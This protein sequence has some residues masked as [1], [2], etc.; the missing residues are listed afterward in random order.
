MKKSL[1]RFLLLVVLNFIVLY[2]STEIDV[3][4]LL[5]DI[6]FVFGQFITDQNFIFILISISISLLTILLLYFFRPFSEIY[7]THYLKSSYYLMLNLVSISTVYLVF[8]IYGYS[9]LYILIY[10][11]LGVLFLQTLDKLF[12]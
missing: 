8:R 2:R 12:K 10:L 6:N 11:V 1:L 5:N 7:L 9:R 4:Q 3:D